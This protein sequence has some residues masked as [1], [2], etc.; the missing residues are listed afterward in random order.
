MTISD[1]IL[2]LTRAS[3]K[4]REDFTMTEKECL[5]NVL[6]VKALMGAFIQ[7]KALVGAFSVIVKT[8]CEID[9]SYAALVSCQSDDR[10][11]IEH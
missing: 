7:E 10:V 11:Y 9:G 3:T 5:N 8:D 4:G 2:L 1:N 6:N